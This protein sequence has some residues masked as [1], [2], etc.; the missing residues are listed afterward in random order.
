MEEMERIREEI[1]EMLE[2]QLAAAEW[3]VQGGSADDYLDFISGGD[4]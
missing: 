1:S 3:E 2:E 4:Y